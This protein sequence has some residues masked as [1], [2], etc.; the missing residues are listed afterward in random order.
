MKKTLKI[1]EK[2]GIKRTVYELFCVKPAQTANSALLMI[3]RQATFHSLILFGKMILLH[4]IGQRN[5]HFVF[6]ADSHF[7]V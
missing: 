3:L 1:R 6:F 5:L 7:V 2:K 4:L